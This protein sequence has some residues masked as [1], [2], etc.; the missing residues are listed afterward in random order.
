VLDAAEVVFADG[1]ASS[2]LTV[3][4]RCLMAHQ[5]AAE[6]ALTDQFAGASSFQT[7]FCARMGLH[8]WHFDSLLS[9][10]FLGAIPHERLRPS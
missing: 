7:F 3:L 1:L 4:F 8:F 2:V 9:Y 5:M 10:F 6:G